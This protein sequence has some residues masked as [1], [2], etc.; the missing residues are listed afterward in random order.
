MSPQRRLGIY[1]GYE[2][3]SIIRYIEPFTGDLFTTRFVDCHFDEAVFPELGGVK[4]NQEKDVTWCEPSLLYLDPRTKQ[5]ETE[6]NTAY[7]LP[8]DTALRIDISIFPSLLS[9]ED[10]S[11]EEKMKIMAETIG[12]IH[13][14]DQTDYESWVRE[15]K[16]VDEKVYAAS[17]GCEQLQRTLSHQGLPTE[18]QKN[19][20]IPRRSLLHER[21]Q[22]MED[23]LSTKNSYE[24]NQ[25]KKDTKKEERK[26][27]SILMSKENPVGELRNRLLL[28]LRNQGS[29]RIKTLQFKSGKLCARLLEDE[30]ISLD[31][32]LEDY[33][34]LNDL[35]E[36]F[37][38]RRNQGDD[39]M[40][41]IEECEVIEE[42]KTRNEDLDTGIDDYP[43]Y[44][45]DDKKIH[46]DCA[47]NLNV[48]TRNFQN[49]K[50]LFL[51]FDF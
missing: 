39:L 13:E 27:N 44:C 43:S 8:L 15:N 10:N 28:P 31:P 21:R 4:K 2:T 26:E 46:I 19:G 30:R 38:L 41:T 18:S 7:P 33:I 5:C 14:Q 47:H 12:V 42:F 16:K 6:L 29:S 40:P 17:S 22:S 24:L 49:F 48:T 1:V 20:K 23:T 9:D 50:L 25:K 37:E 32:F 35:N 11:E 34:E 45:D 51:P 3:S 36:P